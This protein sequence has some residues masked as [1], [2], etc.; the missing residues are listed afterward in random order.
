MILNPCHC[1][2]A[3]AGTENA[4]LRLLKGELHVVEAHDLLHW[5]SGLGV[6]MP[7]DESRTPIEL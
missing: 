3:A 7:D 2:Y 6:G 4:C 1:F 5:Y